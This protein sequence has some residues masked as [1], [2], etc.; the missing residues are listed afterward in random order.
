M[1]LHSSIRL[2]L[3]VGC[4]ALATGCATQT[5][6]P[7][8]SMIERQEQALDAKTLGAI[9]VEQMLEQAR[10]KTS[11][12]APHSSDLKLVFGS[13]A[14]E[15]TAAH[16]DKLNTFAN[17]LTPRTLQID[18]A[19]SQVSD[20]LHAASVAVYRCV[21]ISRFLEK[22]AHNTSIKLVPSMQHDVVRVH[23]DS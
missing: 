19:P 5:T 1:T 21:G 8:L 2:H 16:Q 10:G 17:Q 7:D 20:P 9:S 22:R 15:L 14:Q 18:C 13:G 12:Q 3:I 23:T 6:M 11:N 4:V